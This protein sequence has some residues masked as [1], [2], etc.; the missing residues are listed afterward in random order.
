MDSLVIVLAVIGVVMIL[1]GIARMRRKRRHSWDDIDHSVLFSKDEH[2][3]DDVDSS[4]GEARV[5]GREGSML[6]QD[7]VAVEESL[8]AGDIVLDDERNVV[9]SAAEPLEIKLDA[10]DL[11]EEKAKPKSSTRERTRS[12]LDKLRLD[13]PSRESI[14]ETA[15][16]EQKKGYRDNAPDKVIV[17]NVMAPSGRHFVGSALVDAIEACG[18]KYGEMQ[19]FHYHQDGAAAFSLVNMV[20]P[21]TFDLDNI[22]SLSTP[23]ISLFIQMPNDAGNGLA[24]FDQML[25][26]AKQLAQQLGGELRDEKRSVLT[27]SAIDHIR[28]QIAE[29]DCKWLIPEPA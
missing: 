21:G 5:L 18:M 23:G 25:A 11:A 12:I 28:Q 15:T 3:L 1:A 19:I 29:Y 17:L 6:Q 2:E 24:A 16:E 10:D 27:G 20:N 26:T 22:D 14:E 4:V 8:P 7:A 13:I 9:E